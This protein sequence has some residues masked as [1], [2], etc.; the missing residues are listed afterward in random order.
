MTSIDPRRLAKEI[1][2]IKRL[3]TDPPN[4]RSR[5]VDALEFYSDRTRRSKTMLGSKDAEK[6]YGVPA[7]VYKALERGL[8]QSITKNQEFT[9]ELVEELWQVDY[10]EP[11]LLAIAL[12]D[13]IPFDALL[14]RVE[15]WVGSTKDYQVLTSLA[16]LFVKQWRVER[17]RDFTNILS[18][19]LNRKRLAFELFSLLTLQFL[20]QE[21][22]FED[23]PLIF[24]LIRY[25]DISKHQVV[26][27]AYVD[28]LR[29]LVHRSSSETA[30]YLLDVFEGHPNKARR[31]V[32]E[33]LPEFPSEEQISLK[34]V[35]S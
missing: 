22:D 21:P 10:R 11:K 28:L 30:R 1:D 14:T 15:A 13:Q 29:S 18:K 24:Q 25:H 2:E 27:R 7:P 34:R 19:W 6:K 3:I 20:S 31:L 17:Y 26:K 23:V 16:R 5:I 33:L 12:Q 8:K 4:V 9:S 32:K 35:L